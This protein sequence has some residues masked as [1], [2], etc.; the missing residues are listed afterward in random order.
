MFGR[1]DVL[2]LNDLIR[3]HEVSVGANSV[4]RMSVVVRRGAVGVEEGRQGRKDIGDWD[5]GVGG[6]W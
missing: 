2:A 3:Q 5:I 1:K 6:K 4:V